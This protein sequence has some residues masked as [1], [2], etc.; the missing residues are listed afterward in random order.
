MTS[1][2][3]SEGDGD[4][5]RDDVSGGGALAAFQIVL[6]VVFVVV[7]VV[8]SINSSIDDRRDSLF[9]GERASDGFPLKG[10]ADRPPTKRRDPKWTERSLRSFVA[11]LNHPFGL[12]FRLI[13]VNRGK[14]VFLI[15]IIY[16]SLFFPPLP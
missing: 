4:G 1:R 13:Q 9:C 5:G 8:V 16:F 10:F 11:S 6:V 15:R 14:I 7:V 2:H 12:D 3:G